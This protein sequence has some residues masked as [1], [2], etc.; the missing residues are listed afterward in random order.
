[1][2][3]CVSK[4][5]AKKSKATSKRPSQH[6]K[7]SRVEEVDKKTN[8]EEAITRLDKSKESLEEKISELKQQLPMARYEDKLIPSTVATVY[9][10]ENSMYSHAVHTTEAS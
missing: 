1:M 2:G 9:F 7:A 10:R 8:I 4:Q 5:G 6:R 3:S